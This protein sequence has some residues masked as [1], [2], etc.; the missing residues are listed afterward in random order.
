MKIDEL[1]KECIPDFIM[2]TNVELTLSELQ[3]WDSMAA[4]I[5]VDKMK[6]DYNITLKL[7][8]LS[9]MS[10]LELSSLIPSV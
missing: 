10:V 4:F 6:E 9:K 7:D 8:N 1:L 3:G 2:P 5:L